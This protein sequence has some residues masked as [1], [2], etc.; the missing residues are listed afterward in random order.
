MLVDNQNIIIL[1]PAYH[2]DRNINEICRKLTE[3]NYREIVVVS[4]R[5]EEKGYKEILDETEA[6]GITVLRHSVNQGKGR[7]LKQVLIIL[8]S[9]MWKNWI[10]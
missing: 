1:I 10:C 6:M 4:D 3:K 8:I 5:N 7:A 9:N 2:P